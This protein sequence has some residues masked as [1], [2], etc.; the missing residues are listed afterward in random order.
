M[1][2]GAFAGGA[3][4]ITLYGGTDYTL[5]AGA[6]TLPYHSPIKA[7]FGFSTNPIKWS[8]EVTDN[9]S[10]SQAAPA[11]NTW[12][13]VGAITISIP[14]GC[15]RIYH[16][17]TGQ[18]AD[19][20]SGGWGIQITLSNANNSESDNEFTVQFFQNATTQINMTLT[21]E[22]FLL[23]AAKTS[24]YLNIRTTQANLDNIYIRGDLCKT[25][26]RA[27]CAYL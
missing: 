21:S 25:I 20:T 1:V 17:S 19:A 27:V 12:Y 2:V 14:I 4:L 15:W 11:Q 7:P 9:A 22:K 6:I 10:R 18:L 5:A 23:L 16:K 8:V 26:I 13:N 24:Y 3:T